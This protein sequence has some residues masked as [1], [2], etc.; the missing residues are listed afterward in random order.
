MAL[1]IACEM[2]AER[3]CVSSADEIFMESFTGAEAKVLKVGFEINGA[4]KF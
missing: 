4:V 3:T 2:E 1:E